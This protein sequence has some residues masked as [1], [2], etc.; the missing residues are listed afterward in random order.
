MPGEEHIVITVPKE[1][2]GKFVEIEIH[3][4]PVNAERNP[5]NDNPE[6]AAQ[7]EIELQMLDKMRNQLSVWDI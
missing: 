6:Q 1:L 2:R 5:F 4:T 7:K 3:E